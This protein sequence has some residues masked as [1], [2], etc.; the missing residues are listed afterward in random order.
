MHDGKA[1]GDAVFEVV[2]ASRGVFDREVSQR[3]D[4]AIHSDPYIIWASTEVKFTDDEHGVV[5]VEDN[6]KWPHFFTDDAKA[7]INQD[8]CT[9]RYLW[10]TMESGHT[11][12]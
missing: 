1:R 11:F 5:P 7:R 4:V 3:Q 9:H 10:R 8:D 12:N 6:V 2:A